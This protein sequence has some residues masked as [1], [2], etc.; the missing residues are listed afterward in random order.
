MSE[1]L[2]TN[3]KLLHLDMTSCNISKEDMAIIS[4]GLLKNHTLFGLHVANNGSSYV[5]ESGFI[6]TMGALN[7]EDVSD[8]YNPSVVLASGRPS[9]F[10]HSINGV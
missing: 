9:A 6:A 5:N 1:A 2:S 10:T 8:E 4:S 7:S 3:K